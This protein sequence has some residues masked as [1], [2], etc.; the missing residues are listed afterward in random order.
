M[1]TTS[2]SYLCGLVAVA[3]MVFCTGAA[4]ANWFT[5]KNDTGKPIVV[6][7]TVIVNGQVRR[8]KPT[9]LLAGETLREFIPGPTVKRVEVFDSQAPN[10][11]A[12][13]GNL[14]CKEENQTFSVTTVAGKLSVGQ[15]VQPAKK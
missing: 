7:E 15:I 11:P 3:F 5:L 2:R 9:T 4:S 13:S 8:G 6:Q 14:S 1:F 10:Q 12:W